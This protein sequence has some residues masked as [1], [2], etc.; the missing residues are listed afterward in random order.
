MATADIIDITSLNY[1]G[2]KKTLLPFLNTVI[3]QT[4][5]SSD[6]FCDLFAGSGI[7]GSYFRQKC[8]GVIANDI[9]LYSYVTN[10]GLLTCDY[11]KQLGD[12]IK[13]IN[14]RVLHD[15]NL[16]P[17]VTRDLVYKHFAPSPGCERMFFTCENAVRIDRSRQE[18]ERLYKEEI[19][20]LEEY[21]FLLGSILV[22]ADKL[23]NTTSVYGA[24]LKQFKKSAE[25]CFKV[26]PLHMMTNSHNTTMN[27]VFNMDAQVLGEQFGSD[28]FNIDVIYI[29]PPYC[30]RQYGANYSPLNYIVDYTE[31]NELT[32]KTG[33]IKDYFRSNFASK[34]NVKK[35]FQDIMKV[36]HPQKAIFISYN[37]ESLLN[38]D[39]MTNIFL[40]H[41]DVT[42]YK[43]VYRRYKS[44]AITDG[45]PVYELLFRVDCTSKN[46]RYVENEIV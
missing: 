6:I 30:A 38:Q 17:D 10:R 21:H 18:V 14:D 32:G 43:K 35:A 28:N 40:E 5:E 20:S 9:E 41:G 22:S 27:R 23:A 1:I 26:K 25:Q 46:N 36:L 45:K 24:Y 33:I 12:I 42:L 39:E 3:S 4:L 31:D 13:D 11:T 37:S 19:I 29:D 16:K 7:V 15:N 2:A 44:N 34:S 8:S